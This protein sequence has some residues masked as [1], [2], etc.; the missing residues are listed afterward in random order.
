M[1]PTPDDLAD[2]VSASYRTMRHL[3]ERMDALLDLVLYLE[4]GCAILIGA[5][6]FLIIRK[7][8]QNAQ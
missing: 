1:E 2:T 6:T 7:A 8:I 4:V 5:L 3:G